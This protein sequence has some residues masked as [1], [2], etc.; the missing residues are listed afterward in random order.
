MKKNLIFILFFSLI[1][2]HRV[3]AQTEYGEIK[4]IDADGNITTASQRKERTDSL[5]TNKEI[6][7]GIKV[8]TIDTK[9]GDRKKAIPDT[10]SHMFMNS[11]FTEGIRGEYN[12]LGNLSSPRINRI[13]IDRPLGGQFIFTTPYDF[14]LTK[15]E[16]FL[17]TNTLSP[18]TNLSYNT[19][20]NRTNGEDHFTAR[21]GVNAGKRIGLGF[22]FDYVYG[23]GYYQNQSTAM[24]N[25]T[26]YGSYLGDKYQAHLLFSTN[27]Q[28][29]AENGGITNDNYVKHPELFTDSYQSSEIPT[30]LAENWN[31][32][33]NLHIL[34]TH[35]YN[36]GFN[37]KVRMTDDEIAAR[38]FA[39]EAKKEKELREQKINST[40]SNNNKDKVLP[41]T[42]AGR[43]ENATIVGAEPTD[44][45]ATTNNRLRITS[46]ALSDSLLAIE[47]KKQEDSAWLKNEY[48][49]VTSFI[50][51][52]QFDN[53]KRIYQAYQ[54]PSNFYAQTYYNAGKL[55]GDSIYDRTTHYSIKNTFAI[56]LLEGFNKWAKAGVKVFLTSDLRHFTLPDI[57]AY[58]VG[59]NEHSLS[60]GGQISKTLGKTLHY[61]ALAETWITGVDAGQLKLDVNADINFKLLGD[62]LTLTSN[63]FLYR[64]NPTFYF[65]NYHSRHYWWDNNNLSKILHTRIQAQLLYKKT[66]TKIRFAIDQI[67]N[68]TYFSHS[69]NIN[70]DYSRSNNHMAVIQENNNINLITLELAQ[71][72]SLGPI[73]WESNIT[74]QQSS[75]KTALPVPALN[76]YTN[77]YLRFKIAKVLKCDFGSDLRFFTKYYAPDYNPALGQYAIQAGNTLV[78][79][80]NYPIFNLYANFHLKQTRF[81]IMASHINAGSGKKDYFLTPHYPLNERVIRFGLSWN[82]FN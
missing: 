23:R 47:R 31:R 34:Y 72:I 42:Y 45:T 19:C 53:Y 5:G 24:F 81:F 54:T 32:N 60:F 56:S 9:F 71:D 65:R 2:I 25:Y 41:Q 37:R 39:N 17:F 51:T 26:M 80:G 3:N 35:R 12:T 10:I 52:L 29:M 7:K 73:N 82:F 27:H 43:P 70:S 16:Q 15:E 75:N 6:P 30:V 33:D 8:W 20:G 48:V 79:I 44:S 22:K 18:F 61:N 55:Q 4:Q 77:V 63:A 68:Y 40:Q 67:K 28:K 14:F 74:Y 66:R 21:F 62:T 57:Q 49:P 46:K 59:Y 78:E 50:H 36:I 1:S 69:Y 13:F 38:K 11:I 76:I 58:S 64:L